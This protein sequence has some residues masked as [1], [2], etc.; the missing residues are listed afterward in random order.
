MKWEGDFG[1]E[2]GTL[3]NLREELET[4]DQ[5]GWNMSQEVAGKIDLRYH[6]TEGFLCKEKVEP[7]NGGEG[8]RLENCAGP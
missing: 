6:L 5:P 2:G 3:P 7:P 8:K 1:M 4:R